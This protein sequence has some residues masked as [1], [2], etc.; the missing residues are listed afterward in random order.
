M[1]SKPWRIKV[2][3][4]Q[5]VPLTPLQ[6]LRRVALFE[7]YV[8]QELLEALRAPQREAGGAL[9]AEQAVARLRQLATNSEDGATLGDLSAALEVSRAAMA[10]VG[11]GE[12]LTTQMKID[13]PGRHDLVHKILPGLWCGGWAAL[14]ND[15]F[16]LKQK[17][18]THI[19]S[20]HSQTD[21]RRM[22]PFIKGA[23]LVTVEDD[24][25]ADLLRHF[26]AMCRFI[27]AARRAGG[28]VYVHCG[29]GISRA[30]TAVAAYVMLSGGL[31]AR[32]AV[33]LVK[34]HR[35]CTRPNAGFLAQLRAWEA[36]ALPHCAAR[37]LSPSPAPSPALPPAPPPLGV[38]ET[39]PAVVL[40]SGD[41]CAKT[42]YST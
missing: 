23:M 26:P 6:D 35:P 19:L 18:V 2:G 27:G 20:V 1:A 5:K 10:R 38:L 14:Q 34:K 13:T 29:G 30:P 24:E 16:V 42:P 8:S 36:T 31:P 4:G 40:G 22:P 17:R 7:V 28:S 33:A 37:P 3:K 21:Q 9:A 25:G 12:K 15:C 39:K 11:L 32:A 41:S